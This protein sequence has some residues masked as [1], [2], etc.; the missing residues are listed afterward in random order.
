MT[1][2]YADR[3]YAQAKPEDHRHADIN[4][5]AVGGFQRRGIELVWVKREV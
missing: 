3:A 4:Q 2:L 1:F 5:L